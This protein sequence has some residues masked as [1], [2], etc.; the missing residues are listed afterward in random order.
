MRT[1]VRGFFPLSVLF[2]LSPVLI[3]E[4]MVVLKKKNRGGEGGKL[5]DCVVYAIVLI[6]R[7]FYFQ[8]SRGHR[9]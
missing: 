7:V 2:L 5:V 8:I 4:V 1:S 3:R 6:P 9:T